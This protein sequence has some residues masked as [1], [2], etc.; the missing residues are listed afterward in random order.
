MLSCP[1][2]GVGYKPDATHLCVPTTE[3]GGGTD[4]L[5]PTDE[6]N[7]ALD[8]ALDLSG[9]R[10]G[11][12]RLLECIGEGGVGQVYRAE[13]AT[14]GRK[15]AIKLLRPRLAR[16]A[17]QVQRF[18][19]EAKIVNEIHHENIVEITDFVQSPDGSYYVMELLEG[20]SLSELLDDGPASVETTIEIATQLSSAL[21]LVHGKRV[22]HRDLKPDN[23]FLVDRPSGPDLVKLLDFGVAKLSETGADYYQTQGGRLIGTPSYMAPEQTYGANVDARADIYALGVLMYEMLTGANPYGQG[24]MGEVIEAQ[25]E[26]TPPPPDTIVDAIPSKLSAL[27]MDCLEKAPASRPENMT[28]FAARLSDAGPREARPALRGGWTARRARWLAPAAVALVALG[29]WVSRTRSPPPEPAVHATTTSVLTAP[30]T[31]IEPTADPVEKLSPRLVLPAKKPR[32]RKK[33][34]A[35]RPKRIRRRRAEPARRKLPAKKATTK[36]VPKKPEETKP[37]PKKPEEAKP[38]PKKPKSEPARE[39]DPTERKGFGR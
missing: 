16:Q 20:R 18:F 26:L 15:V 21:E 23:I 5:P 2:C 34:P 8:E 1:K 33:P 10:L 31:S 4:T 36:P 28:A 17:N 30:P 39:I 7:I 38:I 25:R 32:A 14:L 13:H 12:Y 24:N 19:G 27:V 35:R 29:L 22:V 9:T 37:V 6:E 3:P 11:A